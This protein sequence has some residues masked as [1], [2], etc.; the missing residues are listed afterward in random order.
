MRPRKSNSYGS[1]SVETK[2]MNF[3]NQKEIAIIVSLNFNV[4]SVQKFF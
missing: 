4:T 1:K 3:E 2:N